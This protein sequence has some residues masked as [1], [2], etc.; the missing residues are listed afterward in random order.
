MKSWFL[1]RG[2]PENMIDEEMKKVIFLEKGNKKSKGSKGVPFVVT[3]HAC[4]NCTIKDSLNILY[5]SREV[6]A[7]FSPGPMG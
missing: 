3:H 7:V 2:Y 6:K 5:I 4:L 1:K